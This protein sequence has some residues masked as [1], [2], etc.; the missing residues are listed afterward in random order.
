VCVCSDDETQSLYTQIACRPASTEH[1]HVQLLPIQYLQFVLRSN[2]LV[3]MSI[4]T[5][6]KKQNVVA[7]LHEIDVGW[8]IKNNK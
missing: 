4:H 3:N 1:T 6:H 2:A 8:L 5:L 7:Q